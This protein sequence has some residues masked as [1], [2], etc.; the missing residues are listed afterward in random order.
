MTASH[1][2][3]TLTHLPLTDDSESQMNQAD[4]QEASSPDDTEKPAIETWTP[5]KV[6][7]SPYW[8]L[9]NSHG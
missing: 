4:T 9:P 5:W 3:S 8:N 1:D 7:T 6:P 2:R